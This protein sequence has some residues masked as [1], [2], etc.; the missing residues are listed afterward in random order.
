MPATN[1]VP[2]A[3]P[4]REMLGRQSAKVNQSDPSPLSLKP[5]SL[6]IKHDPEALGCANRFR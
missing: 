4:F 2:I 6:V 1:L 5:S 3:G